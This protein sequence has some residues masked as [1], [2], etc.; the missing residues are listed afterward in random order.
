MVAVL[1]NLLIAIICCG[2]VVGGTPHVAGAVNPAQLLGVDKQDDVH[3]S[4]ITLRFNHLP[5]CAIS[6]RGERLDIIMPDTTTSTLVVMPKADERLLRVLVGQGR[7][8]LML[9]FLLRRPPAEVKAFKDIT[10]ATLRL[11]VIWRVFQRQTRPAIARS[12]PG[13][14]SA[15]GGVLQRKIDSRYSGDWVRFYAEYEQP[16][17]VTADMRYTMAPFPCLVLAGKVDDVLPLDV[18]NLVAQEDW[19]QALSVLS[20]VTVRKGKSAADLRL[21]LLKA[22]LFLR[23]GELRRARRLLRYVRKHLEGGHSDLQAC[24]VLLQ[25]YVAAAEASSPFD[26][27]VV[28]SDN[29]RQQYPS[30]MQ[31]YVDLLQAEVDIANGSLDRAAAIMAGALL[32]G[33]GVLEDVY[34]RR[35]ADIVYARGDFVAAAERYA[36][37]EDDVFQA[38]FSCAGYATSLYR[39]HRYKDAVTVLRKLLPLIEDTE[40]LDMARYVL[41]LA[42]I[43]SGKSNA[44][45][46]LLHQIHPGSVGSVLAQ[47][48]IADLGMQVEDIRSRRRSLEDY[49][50]LLDLMPTRAWRA[51]MQFKHALAQYLLGN[52]MAAIEE[53]RYFLHSDHLSE[54]ISQAQALLVDI[55]PGVIHELVQE[56]K[57]FRALVLVE[58]HRDLLVASQRSF[59]FLLELGDIFTRMNLLQRAVHL[60]MYMLDASS[61][62]ANRERIYPALMQALLKQRDYDRV[63]RY[64]AA[65]D[66]EFPAGGANGARVLWL[67]VQALLAEG[68]QDDV[69]ALLQRKNRPRSR[70][71][72]RLAAHIYQQRSLLQQAAASIAYVVGADYTKAAAE[73]VMFQAEL[74]LRRGKLKA[75]LE[76]Y[77]H[78]ATDKTYGDQARYRQGTIMLQLGQRRA[79]LNVLRKLAETATD[80]HWRKL[81]QEAIKIARLQL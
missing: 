74:M 48:K 22:D 27:L 19:G 55:L 34:A 15:S 11:D 49:A 12:L 57:Y 29:A 3:V 44:G 32:R 23:S 54:L 9:S 81:A 77:R 2:V 70:D 78:L 62:P 68:K 50:R 25:M 47:A 31:A 51:E 17:R 75:A 45:Y 18:L 63:K 14:L 1:R 52:R 73:D 26:M 16:L 67:K 46:D 69:F 42:L 61:K 60:Y 39:L 64:G 4:H 30:P 28:L 6:T 35:Q 13:H 37:L 80:E 79:G 7:H 71:I 59:D 8:K 40:Q 24:A 21:R 56:G 72:E 5:E 76:R 38:P 20:S 41:A 58:Q 43:H 33:V 10:G 66:E 65:Y 36:T 53:L